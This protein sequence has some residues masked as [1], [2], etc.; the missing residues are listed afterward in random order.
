MQC[1][2]INPAGYNILNTKSYSIVNL[3]VMG[4]VAYP[5]R[6]MHFIQYNTWVFENNRK[7]AFESC[8]FTMCE[9]CNIS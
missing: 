2:L 7:A 5:V 6:F 8:P 9:S 4:R 1:T 3:L